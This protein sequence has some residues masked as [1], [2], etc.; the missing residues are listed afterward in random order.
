VVGEKYTCDHCGGT[1]NDGWSEEE[2]LEERTKLFGGL[3][4]EDDV[5]LCD[6]CF[7]CLI[8]LMTRSLNAT[9]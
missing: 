5:K 8:N 3:P 2:R 9:T 4:E 6:N 7:K 1:F